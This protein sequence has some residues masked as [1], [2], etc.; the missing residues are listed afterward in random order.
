MTVKKGKA[1]NPGGEVEEQKK[2]ENRTAKEN[3]G[4]KK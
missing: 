1:R 2:N 3:K 4:G